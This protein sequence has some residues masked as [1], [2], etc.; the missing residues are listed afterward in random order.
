MNLIHIVGVVEMVEK[1]HEETR[2]KRELI[3]EAARHLFA[4]QSYDAITIA[5]IAKMAGMAVGTVFFYVR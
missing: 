3:L 4:Q 1:T 2:S 5:D